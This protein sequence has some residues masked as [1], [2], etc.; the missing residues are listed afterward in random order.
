[1][2]GKLTQVQPA[3]EELF[4]L[5]HRSWP[6]RVLFMP[7]LG[8]TVGNLG[9]PLMSTALHSGRAG[10]SRGKGGKQC[11]AEPQHLPDIILSYLCRMNQ[12][13]CLGSENSVGNGTSLH[14]PH[15]RMPSTWRN[16]HV[17]LESKPPE[18]VWAAVGMAKMEGLLSSAGDPEL[19]QT[20][21]SL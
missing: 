15:L 17:L 9:L 6:Y 3:E 7:V 14:I 13:A 18:L 2:L 16:A 10:G 1:M 20:A 8:C 12:A 11:E 21:L 5:I 4:Q 19:E